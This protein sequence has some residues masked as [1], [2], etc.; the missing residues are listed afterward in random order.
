MNGINT[1]W[2]SLWAQKEKYENFYEI[3]YNTGEF[4]WKEIVQE[5]NF[6]MKFYELIFRLP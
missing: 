6:L 2:Q 3:K 5:K 1:Q 4:K